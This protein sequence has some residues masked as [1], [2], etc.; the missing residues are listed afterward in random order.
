MPTITYKNSQ[1][2]VL[3][4]ETVLSAL[5]RQGREMSFSCRKGAC[6]VCMQRCTSG[7]VPVESQRDLKSQ[8]VDKGYF[9][10]CLCF[11]LDSMTIEPPRP[12]DM[13][14]DAHVVTKVHLAPGIIGLFL[15]A[16]IDFS[17]RAGQFV[18]LI[19][20]D[21]STRSYSLAS[22]YGEEPYL[23]LH[24]QHVPGGAVS[25]WLHDEVSVGDLLTLSGP[26]GDNFYRSAEPTRDVVLIGSGT[27]L[28]PIYGIAKSAIYQGHEGD[29]HLYHAGSDCADLYLHQRLLDLSTEY[30]E[31]NYHPFAI[32]A[33]ED[34]R[35]LS[36]KAAISDF[37]LQE[38]ADIGDARIH[39]AGQPATIDRCLDL[40][41]KSGLN[42]ETILADRFD[43]GDLGASDKSDSGKNSKDEQR[44][45]EIG[46]RRFE[47]DLEMWKG[48]EEGKLLRTI[49]D[50]FYTRAF[51]DEILSPYFHNVS[52]QRVA[53]KVYSYLKQAFTG[54]RHYFGNHPR[55]AHHWMVVDNDI[56]DYREK[57]LLDCM[58]RHKLPEPL[59]QKWRSLEEQ[60]RGDIVKDKPWGRLIGGVEC[61]VDGYGEEVL[62]FATLC[63]GCSTEISIGEKVRYHLRLGTVYGHCCNDDV[64][65][66]EAG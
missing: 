33:G 39:V 42:R 44:K 2:E 40:A 51:E 35:L 22:V 3:L 19:R 41:E 45:T 18:N 30:Q 13:C 63:D 43:S 27:G 48:L 8:L 59:I 21:G 64:N 60:F 47:P 46:P 58:Y 15:E 57:M 61:P 20:E 16:E 32:S 62:D 5:L 28:A 56:F 12:E 38:L 65:L 23:E 50:D 7:T 9:L 49:L 6:R 36:E 37:A 10:P 25:E 17:Y 4:G 1:Y 26:F 11:P 34:I 31:F 24:V 66:E 29:I 52:K 55:N 54:E 14:F 53:E